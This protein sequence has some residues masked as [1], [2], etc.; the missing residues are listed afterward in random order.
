MVEAQ[1]A[2]GLSQ[3]NVVGLFSELGQPP[4]LSIL[5]ERL[6]VLGMRCITLP[7]VHSDGMRI[8]AV[9]M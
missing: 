3:Y 5:L 7:V 4:P 2:V 8:V 6:P 1:W 9:A